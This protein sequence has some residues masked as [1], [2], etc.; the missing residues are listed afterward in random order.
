M[1]GI[2][3]GVWGV[4]CDEVRVV[5]REIKGPNQRSGPASELD[6]EEDEGAGC[7][8]D[9][10]EDWREKFFF[11]RLK[12]MPK[13][14]LSRVPETWKGISVPAPSFLLSLIHI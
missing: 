12:S 11:K 4:R 6:G 8:A 2:G 14:V 10:W 13:L 9:G 3:S 5:P 1:W 7:G